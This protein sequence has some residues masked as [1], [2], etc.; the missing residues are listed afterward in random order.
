M[1][2][3]GEGMGS[4]GHRPYV[5]KDTPLARASSGMVPAT[6]DDASSPRN[7]PAL[8][9]HTG[10][11]ASASFAATPQLQDKIFQGTSQCSLQNQE[12]VMLSQAAVAS[13]RQLVPARPLR[14]A[15]FALLFPKEL[16]DL[17]QYLCSTQAAEVPASRDKGN[18]RI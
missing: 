5:P 4:C 6:Q 15:K 12:L 8:S 10:P 1:A 14:W 13:A 3:A 11:L 7:S 18:T 9:S 16:E 17:L 2:E